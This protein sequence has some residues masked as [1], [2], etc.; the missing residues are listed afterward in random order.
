MKLRGFTT[1]WILREAVRSI[2]PAE[3]LSRPKM[4]FPV[5]FGDLDARTV[6]QLA[7]DVLLDS[8]SRQRG[9]IEPAARRAADRRTRSRAPPMAPT[10]SG[11]C[12]TSSSGI[13]RS[14]TARAS[15]RFPPSNRQ[16][17]AD[18]LQATA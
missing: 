12:S 4:G 13:A 7:R 11:A 16:P 15:R 5:P 6:E 3:I 14:S 10:R 9:I 1:K 2:L 8:R 18:R 17:P